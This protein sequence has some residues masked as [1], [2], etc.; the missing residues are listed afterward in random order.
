MNGTPFDHSMTLRKASIGAW[1]SS[2]LPN[3]GEFLMNK[4]VASM[5]RAGH[6]GVKFLPE[7]KL[8]PAPSLKHAVPIVSDNLIDN[9]LSGAVKSVVGI[10]KAVGPT[11]IQLTDGSVVDV[12]AIIW[13]TGYK[14]NFKLLDPAVDP[15]RHTTPL[16]ATLPGSKGKPL[17]RLYRNVF[18][19]D[20]PDSLAFMGGVAFV[21]GAFPLYDIASMAIA[22]IWAGRSSLPSIEEMNASVDEQHEFTCSVAKDGSVIPQWVKERE[23]LAWANDAA[24]TGINQYLGWGLEGWTFWLRNRKLYRL[25]MDGVYTPFI[26]RVFDQGKRKAWADAVDQIEKVNE[27]VAQIKKR[28]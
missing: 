26:F 7:W 20:Y 23:W 15:T 2:Q 18:S 8:E 27:S 12:D 19:L 16:W 21:T 13:C 11:A 24:G 22:Q 17:P 3:V 5:Q 28:V 14:T 4:G 25:M 1:F 10:E 6:K 9:L